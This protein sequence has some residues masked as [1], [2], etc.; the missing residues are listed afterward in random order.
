MIE[1]NELLRV[2]EKGLIHLQAKKEVKQAEVF[3]SANRLN[4]FRLCFASNVSSNALE[5][6]KSTESYGLSVR[7]LFDDGKNGFGKMDSELNESAVEKAFL[8][9]KNSAVNDID[10]KSFAE[11]KGKPKLKNYA[12]NQLIDLDDAVAV[13]LAYSCI[14][15]AFD[16][17]KSNKVNENFNLTGELDFIVERMAVVNSNGI[18]EFDESTI[19]L[20]TLTTIFESKPEV[21]GMW[22]DS[23]TKLNKFKAYDIGLE[24]VNKANALIG[25]KHIDSGNYNAV[26]GRLAF[27][28]LIYSRLD[29]NLG[30]VDVQASPYTEKLDSKIASDKISIYDN[31]IEPDLIGSKKVTC[32]G[33]PTQKTDLIKEGMLVNFLSN[34]YYAKKYSYD[35]RFNSANGFRFGGE[36][37]NYYSEPGIYATNLVV[38]SGEFNDDELI[39]EI[40]NGIYVGRIWYTYPVNGLNSSDFTSTIRGDSYIVKNGEIVSPLIPNTLRINDNMNR[41]LN[42]VLGLSKQQKAALAWGEDSVVLTPEVAVKGLKVERIAKGLY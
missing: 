39:K 34:S 16:S 30:S 32:E 24:S 23:S 40:K 2:A 29:L 42:E 33:L 3:V 8:K 10:F 7:I 22:F 31:G 37:R 9:A 4:T 15:G 17:L 12:D 19:A 14:N 5:E 26:F 28:D 13:D 18:N 41:I 36:G 6:A 20:G 35:K 21:S 38:E 25:G 11:P 27:A 1:L